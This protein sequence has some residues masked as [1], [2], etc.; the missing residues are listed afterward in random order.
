M[1]HLLRACSVG[2]L[3][4]AAALAD[5]PLDLA[6]QAEQLIRSGDKEQAVEVLAKAAQSTPATAES[7]DRIGF[8]YAVLQK[9]DDAILH[10][11]KSV[12]M[13]ASY[14]PAHYHLG[15]ALWNADQHERGLSELKAAAKLD[16]G[17][18]DYQYR[19][20]SA[21][22]RTGDLAGAAE[23]FGKAIALHPDN[24]DLRNTYSSTLIET[25]QADRGI[26]EARAVLAHNPKDLNALMNIGYADLKKGEFDAAEKTYRDAI[27]IDA[28]SPAAHYDL[29]IALKSK[30]ELEA[31]Q[32]EFREAIRLDPSLAQ[33]HYSL[34][35]TDWQLG[36]FEGLTAEMREAIRI[37]PEYAEAHYM[38]GIGLKQ[39]GDLD[40]ALAE[41]RE[42][43]KFDPGTPGPFNTIGQILRVKGDQQGSDEAFATGARIKRENEAQLAN[44]LEQG[45]RGGA[46]MGPM[47]KPMA[48]PIT[49][50]AASS[51]T[52]QRP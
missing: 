22:Q 52:G 15:V 40:G 17:N 19:L 14:A 39:G 41:L 35:I 47:M 34:G 33:A 6:G 27:A 21:C 11:E 37:S 30:D 36:D 20:G 7:E 4:C 9:A 50:G 16:P 29:G 13:N 12:G 25:R 32:K 23:A 26:A 51:A 44:T 1:F 3:V 46:T 2:W 49:P 38:L 5:S 18:F 8:L 45:M 48:Q 31:A 10:F 43:I 42:S 28:M 24:D